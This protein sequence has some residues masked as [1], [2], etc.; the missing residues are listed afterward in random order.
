MAASVPKRVFELATPLTARAG[1]YMYLQPAGNFDRPPI[2]YNAPF[3]TGVRG[4]CHGIQPRFLPARA[5]RLGV[6]VSHALLGVAIGARSRSTETTH[7]SDATPQTLHGAHT[8][9][10]AHPHAPL[11]GLCAGRRAAPAGSLP[12]ATPH[13]PPAGTAAPRGHLAALLPASRLPLSGLGGLGQSP[14]QRTS[15]HL[16][17]RICHIFC[18]ICTTGLQRIRLAS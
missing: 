4:L 8:L 9:C 2:R 15:Y 14:C 6:G 1:P 11:R 17:T 5:D 10:R 18:P 3:T 7:A 13:G 16:S 12:P